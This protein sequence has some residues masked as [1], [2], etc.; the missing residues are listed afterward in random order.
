MQQKMSFHLAHIGLAIMVWAMFRLFKGILP[1]RVTRK[2]SQH[3]PIPQ[4]DTVLQKLKKEVQDET[5][6]NRQ[7]GVRAESTLPTI[8]GMQDRVGKFRLDTRDKEYILEQTRRN[9]SSTSSMDVIPTKSEATSSTSLI[10]AMLQD[11]SAEA[12]LAPLVI[13]AKHDPQPVE[14]PTEMDPPEIVQQEMDLAVPMAA[15]IDTVAAVPLE[16]SVQPTAQR[17]HSRA[18][19]R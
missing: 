12:A 13:D 17:E 1:R 16:P 6:T 3:L 10:D 8:D 9:D 7:L 5:L 18:K 14:S 11:L 2:E 15:V 19:K 4:A